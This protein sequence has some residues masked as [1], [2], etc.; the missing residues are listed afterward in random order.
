MDG[1]EG[2]FGAIGEML[3]GLTGAAAEGA[4]EAVVGRSRRRG[5]R[6]TKPTLSATVGRYLAGAPRALNVNDL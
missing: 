5:D 2:L 1:I 3:G 4:P 6:R